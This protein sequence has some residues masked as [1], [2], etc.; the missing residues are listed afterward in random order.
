MKEVLTK[1]NMSSGKPAKKA[2]QKLT[3]ANTKDVA[4]VSSLV[5]QSIKTK[6]D[7]VESSKVDIFKQL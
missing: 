5:Q 2:K 7:R 4:V 6:K 3:L 1:A